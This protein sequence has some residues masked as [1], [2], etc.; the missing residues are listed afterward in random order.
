MTLED[1]RVTGG[2]GSAIAELLGRT[3]PTALQMIGIPDVY[4]V[5]G[6]PE[7]LYREYRMDVPAVVTAA[8]ELCGASREEVTG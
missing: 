7:E 8:R 3:R 4:P 6:N 5:V 1:N 2:F